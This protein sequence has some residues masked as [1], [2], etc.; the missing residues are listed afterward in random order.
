MKLIKFAFILALGGVCGY[1][2]EATRVQLTCEADDGATIIHG[3][4]YLCFT[5]RQI[6]QM[7]RGHGDSA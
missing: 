1:Q 3:V 7:Q 6:N 2:I 4:P 5:Q